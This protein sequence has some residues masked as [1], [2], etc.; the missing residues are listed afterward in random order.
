M[1]DSLNVA[2]DYGLT[3]ADLQ[4]HMDQNELFL[5]PSQTHLVAQKKVL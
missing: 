4:K 3:Q 5:V 1:I 2:Y